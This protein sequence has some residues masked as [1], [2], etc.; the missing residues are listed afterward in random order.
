MSDG[1]SISLFFFLS[2]IVYS[3]GFISSCRFRLAASVDAFLSVLAFCPIY[4]TNLEER[5]QFQFH[6]MSDHH[7]LPFT[8]SCRLHVLTSRWDILYWLAK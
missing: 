2:F 4:H 8:A 3:G 1:D 5:S 7:T 6:H